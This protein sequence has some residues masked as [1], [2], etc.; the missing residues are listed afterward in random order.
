MKRWGVR[1]LVLLGALQATAIGGCSLSSPRAQAVAQTS[2]SRPPPSTSPVPSNAGLLT[3]LLRRAESSPAHP[4]TDRL[5]QAGGVEPPPPPPPPPIAHPP[6]APSARRRHRRERLS[7]AVTSDASVADS[8]IAADP[9][10][11]PPPP[12]P[13]PE[14]LPAG[15]SPDPEAPS[16]FARWNQCVDPNAYDAHADLESFTDPQL[17]LVLPRILAALACP[18]QSAACIAVHI[19][20][21]GYLCGV[22]TWGR[23]TRFNW[24]MF[25]DALG[26]LQTSIDSSAGLYLVM[27]VMAHEQGHVMLNK[28]PNSAGALQIFRG[29]F[30][31][32]H[33]ASYEDSD[34]R[35]R[36]LYS[37]HIAGFVLARLGL[38]TDDLARFVRGIQQ[39]ETPTHPDPEL[40]RKAVLFGWSARDG[41]W[42]GQAFDAVRSTV[43]EEMR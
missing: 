34:P 1:A 19:R 39:V 12:S 40:R 15:P 29:E 37:D 22:A 24:P 25:R 17:F 23:T 36:E 2:L 28:L 20:N 16:C 5:I 32:R 38:R 3:A 43:E 9:I 11:P 14:E 27:G 33:S 8:A 31:S 6:T 26:G 7:A 18:Q 41:L 10:A 21:D 30:R 13:P 4:W 42:S 35:W